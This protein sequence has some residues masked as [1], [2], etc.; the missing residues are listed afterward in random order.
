LEPCSAGTKHNVKIMRE[1]GGDMRKF[2]L[3][4]RK[5]FFK[6]FIYEIKFWPLEKLLVAVLENFSLGNEIF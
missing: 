2:F 1:I 3:K 5:F 4:I 6:D